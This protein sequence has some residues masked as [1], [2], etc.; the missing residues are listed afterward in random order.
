MIP[1][2]T[3]IIG[4]FMISNIENSNHTVI[5]Y[6]NSKISRPAKFS[7][8]IYRLFCERIEDVMA[9]YIFQP[10]Q[11]NISCWII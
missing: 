8:P 3:V 6:K 7:I 9:R 10:A 1:N 4:P 5:F 2:I 11:S